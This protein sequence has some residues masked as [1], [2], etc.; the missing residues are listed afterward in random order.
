M[1]GEPDQPR[2]DQ[3][4]RSRGPARRAAALGSCRSP[5]RPRGQKLAGFNVINNRLQDCKE[6]ADQ[7]A[8]QQVVGYFDPEVRLLAS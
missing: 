7:R 2:E 4:R 1:R 8:L 3:R 5:A 6:K